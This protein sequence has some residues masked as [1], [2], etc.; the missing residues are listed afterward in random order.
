[1]NANQS[2]GD[3]DKILAYAYPGST[4]AALLGFAKT[5]CWYVGNHGF[6]TRGEAVAYGETLPG[7]WGYWSANNP[8]FSQEA[9][10][11]NQPEKV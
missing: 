11:F 5:G 9:D 10:A 3:A 7:R 2:D 1:M 6:A 8:R 4:N